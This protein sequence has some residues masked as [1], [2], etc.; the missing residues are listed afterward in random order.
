MEQ[1]TQEFFTRTRLHAVGVDWQPNE[2][3]VVNFKLQFRFDT[4]ADAR[5]IAAAWRRGLEKIIQDARD[6]MGEAKKD[7]KEKAF[8]SSMIALLEQA[9]I[10]TRQTAS[11]WQIDVQLKG[12][13]D[14][15]SHL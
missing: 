8:A 15:E 10:E 14:I 7:E 2:G 13:I 4:E 9:R 6:G 12:T 3:G 1:L 11:G 5:M